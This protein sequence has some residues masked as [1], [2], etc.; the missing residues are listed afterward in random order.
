MSTTEI[1]SI[2]TTGV[3]MDDDALEKKQKSR[4][5]RVVA[6]IRVMG[7]TFSLLVLPLDTME[8]VLLVSRLLPPAYKIN[9]T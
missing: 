6:M 1:L 4:A 5:R 3:R 7:I 9:I 8:C 2:T